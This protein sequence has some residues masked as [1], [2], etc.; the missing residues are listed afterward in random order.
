MQVDTSWQ[1]AQGGLGIGLSLVKEFVGLH[2]GRVEAHSDGPGKGSEF[3]V[4]LPVDGGP[5]RTAD[6]P[7]PSRLADRSAASSWWTT[8]R[9]RPSR[10]R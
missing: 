2:G 8:T 5:R 9:T 10:S 1:R 3:V 7:R 4:R 6:P